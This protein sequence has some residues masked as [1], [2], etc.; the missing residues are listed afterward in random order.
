MQRSILFAT[1]YTIL[2][3][4]LL[5]TVLIQAKIKT[6]FVVLEGFRVPAAIFCAIVRRHIR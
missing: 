3:I 1:N 6:N 2:P 4:C 5:V